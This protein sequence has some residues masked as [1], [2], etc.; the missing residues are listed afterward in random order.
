[1]SDKVIELAFFRKRMPDQEKTG[2]LI[3][4]HG[5][6]VR[7]STPEG[8]VEWKPP[9]R[10]T[11]VV[12]DIIRFA[13]DRPKSIEPRR[14]ELARASDQRGARQVL[15]ANLDCLAIVTAC[16]DLFKPGLIDRFAVAASHA[17]IDAVIVINKIDI[18]DSGRFIRAVAEYESLG[19]EVFPTSATSGLGIERLKKS[20]SGLTST[21]VGHSGVGKSSLINK[22]IPG[23]DRLVAKEFGDAGK[24]RHTTTSSLMIDMPGGGALID[25][26]GIRLFSPTG[27][28]PADVAAHFPG[29]S[30][31][32]GG[33]KFRDCLHVSE[34]GCSIRDGVQNG[35]IDK[36]RY[37][38]YIRILQSAKEGDVPSWRQPG[39]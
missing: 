36:D 38:S 11:W 10:Q 7:I 27:V 26:P 37:A 39:P 4:H 12:G 17:G 19:Y 18:P 23:V 6:K 8:V 21:M 15:A 31:Y 29:F 14:N 9:R 2:R 22:L 34:P 5:L 20:L 32:S 13:G 28:S 33:C 16:G 3:A 35:R 25:S 24:G 1:L 30:A